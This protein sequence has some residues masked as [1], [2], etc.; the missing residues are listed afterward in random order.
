MRA[1]GARCFNSVITRGRDRVVLMTELAYNGCPKV[2]LRGGRR[3]EREG[4]ARI[5]VE[6]SQHG[7]GGVANVPLVARI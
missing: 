3:L 4:D 5:T 6:Q 1:L 7:V 2:R